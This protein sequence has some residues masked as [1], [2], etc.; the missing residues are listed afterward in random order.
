MLHRFIPLAFIA[1]T[2]VTG[3]HLYSATT[4]ETDV[5]FSRD[6]RPILS[7][8]CFKCHGPDEKSRKGKLRLDIREEALKS[9]KSGELAIVPG[10]PEASELIARIF[11]HDDDEIMPPP[12]AKKEITEAQKQILK[13]WI[14]DGAEYVQHWAFIKP[15]QAPIP[16]IPASPAR[17]T[18]APR[19]GECPN[20]ID[21]FIGAA[22]SKQG[23]KPSPQ[24]D[25][26]TLARRVSLDLIGRAATP[27]E[28]QS[29]VQDQ[30][31]DAYEKF[32][33][34]LLASPL[35]GERWA[36]KWLDLARY[37]DTNG[38]EKDRPRTIWPF[39]DWVI[40]ALNDDKP[41]DQFTI[42][43]LAGDM[44]PQASVPQIV[45][46]GFH[47]NT[48]LNEEGGIDPLEFRF[49]SVTDRLATTGKTWLG[50]TIQCA[51][52]HTH[53]YDPI[54]HREY[55]Q[56]MAFFN[57]ADEPDFDLLPPDPKARLTEIQAKIDKI[58]AE[59]PG[60]FAIEE[61]SADWHPSTFQPKKP[62]NA[63]ARTQLGL[64]QNQEL[65]QAAGGFRWLPNATTKD[66]R[67]IEER[68]KEAL[69]KAFSEW[70]VKE[71]AA[72]T[73]WTVLTP[74]SAK[75]N[76]PLL[77]ILEDASVLASGDQTRAD[78]YTLKFPPSLAGI[79]AIRLE[80]L[81]DDSLPGH[82]PGRTF[83]EGE[84]G[85][86]ILTNFTASAGEK[87]L[88]FATASDSFASA[89]NHALKAI[90]ADLQSGWSVDGGIGCAHDAVFNLAQPL[91]APQE[92]T[93]VLH[94]EQYYSSNLGRFRLSVTADPQ[95]G[96]A[97]ETPENIE[98]I[99]RLPAAQR[100]P[101]QLAQLREQ[102]LLSTP[103]LAEARQEINQ[104]QAQTFELPTTLVMKE[105][106]PQNPRPTF[107]HNRGEFLSETDPVS[108][109]VLA[110][111]NPLPKVDKPTRLDF[112][113]WLVSPEH[114]L[115]ARVTVNRQWAAFFG[116]GIVSTVDDF[117][118]QGEAPS[119]QALLDWLAVEFMKEGWSL[120][121]LH[122]RIVTSATY[123]QSSKVSPELLAKD[124][125]NR[126][127]ARGPR[128]RL[129]A[130]MIRDSLLSA[131]DLLSKKIGGPSVYPPQPPGV[132]DATFGTVE[133]K[134]STG[135]DR[136]RR[137]LYT[138]AKR[139]APYAMS[140]NFDAPV[141]DICVAQ[142]EVSNTPLQALAMLNDTVIFEAAQELGKIMVKQSG[143]VSERVGILFQRC[144]G[145]PPTPAEST[146]LQQFL[147]DQI[148]RCQ[149]GK[150]D[151]AALSGPGLGDIHQ[152]A[153]WTALARAIFNLDEALTK[154]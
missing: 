19:A 57:N 35:Y 150:L 29:F 40:K 91:A 38:Y 105:R 127:L 11:S 133:W 95:P 80:A 121:K 109:G 153:A 104:L 151:S 42:E 70:L 34:G 9:G 98:E 85:D 102:F 69:E 129:E 73:R 63:S 46:T 16:A 114:P 78:T 66:Q 51:Q 74:S 118:F 58:K 115:T 75:S 107:I 5:Q 99:L 76:L 84:K 72:A 3:P 110:V 108:P 21:A 27:A 103:E 94:C 65:P 48:M 53:K 88:T 59:L 55:Y 152:R 146:Q 149:T 86:F 1:A 122:K 20:P 126:L 106:P 13:T 135:E 4:Q 33:D 17:P 142:R 136:Y 10:K 101:G 28:A 134:A 54:T 111:L 18:G 14:T 113:R 147:A 41:F 43:Q 62:F 120:K 32:V 68:R 92:L 26:Y 137:G 22:L 44:L 81:P 12:A 49:N 125:A 37:A 138:F 93:V 89:K 67:P 100:S 79:T 8:H 119:N 148:L 140:S 45:A 131:S 77:T 61:D 82:G 124:P 6:V 36:R 128:F 116:R 96:T 30:A 31:P 90:D 145:R 141:G 117:G 24:A 23:L 139:T 154:G 132:Q 50:L 143:S 47:R 87:P 123:Q 52:C 130:E 144:L 25:R 112:A 64:T 15:V 2:L 39:R 60:R 83:Y 7:Q 97:R 71:S 56:M